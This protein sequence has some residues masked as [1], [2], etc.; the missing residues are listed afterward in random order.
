MTGNPSTSRRH[1]RRTMLAAAAAVVGVAVAGAAAATTGWFDTPS[2]EQVIAERSAKVMPFDLDA[3]THVFTPSAEGG[4]QTVTA[5]DS[6]DRQ[7]IDLIQQHLRDEV[8]AFSRGDFGDP[9]R[10]HGSGMPGL[11]ALEAGAG[12]IVVEYQPLDNGGKVRYATGDQALVAALHDWFA[13]QTTDHTGHA[14]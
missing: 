11:A 10:V 1:R 8:A 2:R 12:R 6:S 3:T 5:D 13:A 9:A 4:T 7:Q 14:G